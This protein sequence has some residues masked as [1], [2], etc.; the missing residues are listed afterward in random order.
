ME[1]LSVKKL[2]IVKILKNSTDVKSA[3][4]DTLCWMKIIIPREE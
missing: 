4:K 3:R 1:L 2:K